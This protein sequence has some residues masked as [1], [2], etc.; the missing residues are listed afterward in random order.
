MKPNNEIQF[1]NFFFIL[2]YHGTL[3][4]KSHR[5]VSIF[6]NAPLSTQLKSNCNSQVHVHRHNTLV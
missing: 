2:P 5:C 6:H 4:S 1:G 3:D